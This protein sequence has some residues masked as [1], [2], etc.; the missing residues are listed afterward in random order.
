MHSTGDVT[1]DL[2][3]GVVRQAIKDARRGRLDAVAWL[4]VCAPE[5][6]RYTKNGGD[7]MAIEMDGREVVADLGV[8]HGVQIPES[9]PVVDES[10]R[11]KARRKFAEAHSVDERYLPADWRPGQ[12][13]AAADPEPAQ[14]L[15]LE[16][17]A[18][19]YGVSL[20]YLRAANSPVDERQLER[21]RISALYGVSAKYVRL[22]GENES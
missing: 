5:W 22:P 10:E 21:E 13:A 8:A 3:A 14:E 2:L 19:R 16:S 1:L 17:L 9:P 15:D 7:G 18:S 4:D 12:E 11:A 20:K 6:R